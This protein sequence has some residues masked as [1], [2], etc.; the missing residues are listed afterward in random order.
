MRPG[1]CAHRAWSYFFRRTPKVTNPRPSNRFMKIKPIKPDDSNTGAKVVTGG[2]SVDRLVRPIRVTLSRKKGWAMP[3]NT[4]S[5]SRPGIF[6]NPFRVD[7]RCTQARAVELFGM[8]INGNTERYPDLDERLNV[9]L[10]A[11]PKLRGKNLA[12]WCKAGTPC[13]A[14]VLLDLANT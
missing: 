11:L 10:R 13:H 9:L 4:V 7:A 5:V 12:C 2:D 14:D 3:D 8:W 6:G 1:F